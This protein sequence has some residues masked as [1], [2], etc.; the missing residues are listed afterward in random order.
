M[1]NPNDPIGNRIHVLPAFRVVSQTSLQFT[2]VFHCMPA[3]CTIGTGFF[4]GARERPGREA[5]P[6]PP[7]SAVVKK[8]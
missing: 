8:E 1:K 3:S 4:P 7:S 2:A 6:S 5:D